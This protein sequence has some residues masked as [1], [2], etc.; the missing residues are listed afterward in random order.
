MVRTWLTSGKKCQNH[1]S[2][3]SFS[4]VKVTSVDFKGEGSPKIGDSRRG[5]RAAG[6]KKKASEK[7]KDSGMI[8]VYQKTPLPPAALPAQVKNHPAAHNTQ[9]TSHNARC[10]GGL[11]G[12][13]AS[14]HSGCD[15]P[16]PILLFAICGKNI[17]HS[18][19]TNIPEK[20][21]PAGNCVFALPAEGR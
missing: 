13:G 16:S 19:T 17:K 14:R 20:T 8:A 6:G 9:H 10:R 15:I 21:F 18:I 12:A 4:P 2:F 3:L 1:F 5:D 7:K 11:N